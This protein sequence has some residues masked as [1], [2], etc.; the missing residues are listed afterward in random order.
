MGMT[1]FT[2]MTM[3]AV[4]QKARTRM[5]RSSAAVRVIEFEFP[6]LT[7]STL[8]YFSQAAG[9]SRVLPGAARE[10]LRGQQP[11]AGEFAPAF[12]CKNNGNIFYGQLDL[13]SA[14]LRVNPG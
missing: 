2:P 14:R 10:A 1:L 5:R 11:P 4:E 12:A 3:Q 13:L 6:S 8:L 9:R 7:N